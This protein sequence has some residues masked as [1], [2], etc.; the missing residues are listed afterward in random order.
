MGRLQFLSI[1]L[2][3]KV[4]HVG[5]WFIPNLALTREIALDPFR[6]PFGDPEAHYL[7]HTWLSPLLSWLL[8]ADTFT[9]VL[10][11]HL[12]FTWLFLIVVTL[13]LFEALPEPQARVA[14]IIFWSAPVS[15]VSLYWIGP[16]SLTLFL[17]AS[18]CVLNRRP[19]VVFVIGLLLGLQHFEQGMFGAISML[20]LTLFPS[21]DRWAPNVGRS[22]IPLLFSGL[23]SGK[24]ALLAIFST[25][26]E[27]VNSGRLYWLITNFA[28]LTADFVSLP[29]ITLWS[30]LGL[31]WIAL[32][33]FAR[34]VR[35]GARV[36]VALAIPCSV[37][38][39]VADPTRVLAITSFPLLYFTVLTNHQHLTRWG[40]SQVTRWIV[41]A[42][43][44]PWLWVWGGEV[45]T[46]TVFYDAVWLINQ[47]SGRFEVPNDLA[48]WPF[49]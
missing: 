40:G 26:P 27:D 9:K 24:I 15:G 11:L 31:C 45:H 4:V 6:N 28:S 34:E 12:C 22:F 23:V 20:P 14:L 43:L 48:L 8:G 25:F 33:K 32:A 35:C 37:L 5:V 17:L 41:T 16:D 18:A 21:R 29:L 42:V 38:P 13:T 19:S 49:R 3:L 30:G 47:T 46:S 44:V 7:L 36:L 39:V 1:L 2:A 10:L